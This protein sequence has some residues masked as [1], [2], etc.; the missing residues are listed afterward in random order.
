[1]AQIFTHP[2]HLLERAG[3]NELFE[4]RKIHKDMAGVKSDWDAQNYYGAGV[5]SG[6][7]LTA[8][9]TPGMPLGAIPKFFEGFVPQFVKDEN[10]VGIEGCYTGGKD[11][12]THI[13][14]AIKDFEKGSTLSITR[15]IVQLKDV[16]AEL[17]KEV[18]SCKAIGGDI[19]AI[20][21]WAS[22]FTNKTK[23][24]AK[25]TKNLT[26]HRKE[27]M[28]DIATLKSDFTAKNYFKSG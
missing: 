10:L 5:Y 11:V 14:A 4:H 16:I 19:S 15:G 21:S 6:N 18:S 13:E 12:A 23:L 3:K 26:F 24:V 7:F 17:P 20:K 22:L 25:I 1:M 27:I 9:L 28:S 8:L 2:V